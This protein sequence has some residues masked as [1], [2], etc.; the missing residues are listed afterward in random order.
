MWIVEFAEASKHNLMNE[1][2]DV[3]EQTTFSW[4]KGIWD[5]NT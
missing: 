3:N 4:R 1:T 2:V 5:E